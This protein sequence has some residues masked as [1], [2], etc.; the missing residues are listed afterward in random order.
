MRYA[1]AYRILDHDDKGCCD[2]SNYLLLNSVGY[3]EFDETF[4]ATHRKMGRKDYYLSY[5]HSGVMKVLSN[6]KYCDISAGDI[7]IYKPFEEQYYGQANNEHISNYWVHFTGYGAQEVLINAKISENGIFNIGVSPDIVNIFENIL[8][9]VTEKKIGY[10]LIS[11]SLLMQ[12]LSLI[13]RKAEVV[14]SPEISFKG[15]RINES[16]KY[17]H[18]NY[19][20]KIAITSLAAICHI[21]VNRYSYVFKELMRVSP[22]QY[23]INLRLQKSCELM[24]HTNLNIKQI[25]SLVG[26]EDQLYFSRI[27]KK[28]EKITPS[29][30]LYNVK[31][32]D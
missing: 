23:I 8:I 10:D 6:G 4:G 16:I 11:T 24:R 32:I 30:Y 31:N 17:I 12:I 25:S 15:K 27:F 28:Y 5:N 1:S 21:S 7:F 18:K 13:S 3:Y 20:K 22:Q 29:Q 26:F 14:D 9:E 2:R 19:G